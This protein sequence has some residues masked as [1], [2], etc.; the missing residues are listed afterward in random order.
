MQSLLSGF[1]LSDCL[2]TKASPTCSS[3]F[4]TLSPCTDAAETPYETAQAGSV[5]YSSAKEVGQER[6]TY[7]AVTGRAY[8]D[9]AAECDVE[10]RD[11]TTNAMQKQ[12][13][14]RLQEQEE[15]IYVLEA[16]LQ[17]AQERLAEVTS[18]EAKHPPKNGELTLRIMEASAADTLATE[19][20][21]VKLEAKWEDHLVA[22]TCKPPKVR[23]MGV[24]HGAVHIMWNELHTMRIP[25]K[26]EDLGFVVVA[27]VREDGKELASASLSMQA[28]SDQQVLQQWYV[29]SN[30][31]KACLAMQYIRSPSEIL[32]NHVAMFQERLA[33]ARASL[34]EQDCRQPG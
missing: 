14:S 18:F 23:D 4:F 20:Y 19:G 21:N 10:M 6:S 12:S 13:Q 22:T 25:W 16:L 31:W 9:Q 7:E 28:F 27:I 32:R 2:S 34:E 3:D 33:K 29:L 24:H 26:P 8:Q 11:K 5:R 30:G 15:D 17:T 1:F